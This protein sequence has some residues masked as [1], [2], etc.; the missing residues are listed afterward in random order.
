MYSFLSDC[1]KIEELACKI[2]QHLAGNRALD[3][4]VRQLF[5]RLSN[6]ERSH[7]QHLDLVLQ[8]SSKEIDAIPSVSREKIR[9]AK[10]LA[11]QLFYMVDRGGLNNEKALQLAEQM[12]QEFVKAHVHNSVHFYDKN[13]SELFDKLRIEDQDHIDALNDC[14][15]W[16]RRKVRAEKAQNEINN[17]TLNR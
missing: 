7:A 11:E 6:D 3:K 10:I 12:E 9:D 17:K 15:K 13:V 16:W 5:L 1:H 4:E 8:A 2:Y 14:L